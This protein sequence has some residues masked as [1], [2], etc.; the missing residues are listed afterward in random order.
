[1][2]AEN[3]TPDGAAQ[4]H[5]IIRREQTLAIILGASEWPY[6][7]QFEDA[8][9]FR[10]SAHDIA[11]YLRSPLGLKLPLRNVKELIDSTDD[12]PTILRQM[13]NFIR[14]RKY[15][16]SSRGMQLTDL[17]FYYVGHG[18]LTNSSAFFLA[19]R[20]TDKD[21]PLGTSI[22]ADSLGHCHGNRG[23]WACAAWRRMVG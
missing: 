18:G 3:S 8:P 17:V 1:M 15:H 2:M 21:N 9:N 23:W 16:L 22:T 4:Y 14:E 7:P 11:D 6:Y 19:I 20:S 12:A 10:R 5:P 13:R